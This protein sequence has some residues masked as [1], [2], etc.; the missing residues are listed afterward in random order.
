M[1]TLK[2][3]AQV[4]GQT[5]SNLDPDMVITLDSHEGVQISSKT[6]D[7]I[8]YQFLKEVD[9]DTEYNLNLTFVYKDQ[10]KLVVPMSFLNKKAQP[11]FNLNVEW[12][13]K[14]EE[15]V[16]GSSNRIYF[17]VT[18]D[19]GTPVDGVALK[20]LNVV[21]KPN[22]PNLISGYSNRI[23]DTKPGGIYAISI[24]LNYLAGPFNINMVLSKDNFEFMIPKKEYNNPGTKV[25]VSFDPLK[26][27]ATESK[28]LVTA[29]VVQNEYATLGSPRAGK[30]TNLNV[31]G[32]MVGP[33]PD[34]VTDSNGKCT[35]EIIP[36]GKLEDIVLT[37]KFTADLYNQVVD[38]TQEFKVEK[39]SLTVEL[40]SNKNLGFLN[41]STVVARILNSKGEPLQQPGSIKNTNVTTTPATD[42]MSLVPDVFMQDSEDKTL[43]KM[44]VDVSYLPGTLTITPEIII[45]GV[46]YS[47]DTQLLFETEG[48][49]ITVSRLNSEIDSYKTTPLGIYFTRRTE[50]DSET[51]MLF[52]SEVVEQTPS[53]GLKIIT[54]YTFIS[55]GNA[56]GQISSDEPETTQYITFTVAEEIQGIKYTY[57]NLT[58]DI[59]VKE[60]PPNV[61]AKRIND[62]DLS[63]NV[64]NNFYFDLVDQNNE[65]VTDAVL[66]GT[67]KIMSDGPAVLVGDKG[68]MFTDQS[69]PGRYYLT[70]TPGWMPGKITMD[71]SIVHNNTIFKLNKLVWTNP[72]TPLVI[73]SDP[74]EIP[75]PTDTALNITVQQLRTGNIMK[76]IEGTLIGNPN[77]NIGIN[78]TSTFSPVNGKPGEYSVWVMSGTGEGDMRLGIDIKEDYFGQT[79][80]FKDQSVL[81]KQSPE[82]SFAITNFDAEYKM[83]LWDTKELAYTV[84]KDNIDITS[85]VVDIKCN[86]YDEIKDHFEFVKDEN[87]KWA[88]R[89][90]KS[91]TTEPISNKASLMLKVTYEGTT[92]DLPLNVNLITNPNSDPKPEFNVEII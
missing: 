3:A 4:D 50:I 6:E 23:V 17:K 24:N 71:I 43:Y 68:K 51:T 65:P 86:N 16:G 45:G 55:K 10:Y 2:Q 38:F 28:Q 35:I 8:T 27:L 26:V 78:P 20:S 70:G 56:N 12:T 29:S 21:G 85:S 19:Q 47:T 44:D 30:F 79:L 58:L 83:N 40:V 34:A 72:G 81:I 36:N 80:E 46:S 39:D 7:T 32:G 88:F 1:S 74:T 75:R 76:G 13:T 14:D 64:E 91:D 31:T 52:G 77:L 18:D 42:V 66:S 9:Q 87:G 5:I 25:S 37:G 57:D 41:K 48:S 67:A 11:K 61:I 49:P 90:I 60:A 62:D 82:T 69:V 33:I 63:P 73:T 92:A 22:T 15:L 59:K 54:P 89:S 53:A 84:K